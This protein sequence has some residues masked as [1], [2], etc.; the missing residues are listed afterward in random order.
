MVDAFRASLCLTYRSVMNLGFVKIELNGL[1]RV[2]T[3]LDL[4]FV[5]RFAC[6]VTLCRRFWLG[7]RR[8]QV[9]TYPGGVPTIGLGFVWFAATDER[10]KL[11]VLHGDLTTPITVSERQ[12]LLST[13]RVAGS[14]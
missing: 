12:R 1:P 13:F 10:R 11:T 14:N 5:D 2:M 3:Y 9:P 8:V 6:S 7:F 4:V